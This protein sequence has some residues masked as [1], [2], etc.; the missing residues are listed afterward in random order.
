[1]NDQLVPGLKDEDHG[2]QQSGLVVEPQTKFSVGRAILVE[3]LDPQRP[4]G[5]LDSILRRDAVLEGAA[6]DP[7]RSEV[8]ECGPDRLGP[9]HLVLGSSRVQSIELLGGKPDRHNLH[10]FST[11]A[12]TPAAPPLEGVDVVARLGL[13]GPSLDLVL[14][15][16][17]H[18]V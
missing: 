15:H 5:R 7:S 11:S 3:R 2:L 13:I 12:G 17:R 1:M 4:R 8:G 14:T 9:A 10:R 6:M 16:H 18:I